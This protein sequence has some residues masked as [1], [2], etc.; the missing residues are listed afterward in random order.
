MINIASTIKSM[1]FMVGD[2]VALC[3]LMDGGW[4]IFPFAGRC[5]PEFC[6]IMAA[7]RRKCN[8][9]VERKDH[10]PTKA[11]FS[12][13]PFSGVIIH[14]NY[15]CIYTFWVLFVLLKHL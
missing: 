9:R 13:Y 15:H 12:T 14:I 2:K 11:A 7:D 6:A 8:R 5:L 1:P 10:P 3:D 4:G